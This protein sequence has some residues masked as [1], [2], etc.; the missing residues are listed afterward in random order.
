MDRKGQGLSLNTIIVAII[1][2]IVLVVIIM[3]FTG[4]FG[5]RFTPQVTNCANSGGI[6]TDGSDCGTDAFGN[7]LRSISGTCP[8]DTQVCCAKGIGSG[9][10]TTDYSNYGSAGEKCRPLDQFATACDSGLQCA[11]GTCRAPCTAK[12]G[13]SIATSA[14]CTAASGTVVSG[15]CSSGV[16]CAVLN[17]KDQTLPSIPLM[18]TQ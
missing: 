4:Y 14:A 17:T 9:G 1:V 13:C 2:L 6:C 7:P 10:K 5:T 12:P 16:C 8:V 15:Y 11:S 3:L 18:P